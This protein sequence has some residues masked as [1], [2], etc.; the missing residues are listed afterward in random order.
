MPY[1]MLNYWLNDWLNENCNLEIQ[2]ILSQIIISGKVISNRIKNSPFTQFINNYAD[3]ISNVSNITNF[4]GEEVKTLDVIAN[5]EFIK[6]LSKSKYVASMISEEEYSVLENDNNNTNNSV[7]KYYVTFDPLDGSSNID[8]NVNIGSIFGIYKLNS[9]TDY[10]QPGKNIVCSGYILYG[11]ST[12]III[13][14]NNSV[15]GFCLNEQIG[16]F[17]LTHQ[18]MKIPIEKNIYS[19]NEGNYNFWDDKMKNFTLHLKT[20]DKPYSLRYIGSMVADIHRTLLYGGLFMYPRSSKAKN[21]K[22]RYLYE[23]APMAHIIINAGGLAFIDNVNALDYVPK[24][25]HETVPIFIGSK[26]CIELAQNYLF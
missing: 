21:G 22:L 16:E 4:H 3:N 25:I 7:N 13:S 6:N 2:N 24:S 18:N 19:V 1:N 26:K 17:I 9:Q 23:V 5:N 14:M 12:F 15:N 20:L 10:L 8:A 11:S